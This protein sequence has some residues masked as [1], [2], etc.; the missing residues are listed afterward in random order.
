MKKL[1][2]VFAALGLC[3]LSACHVPT[4]ETSDTGHI[5]PTVSKA[6]YMTHEETQTYDW[7]CD[8]P[9]TQIK[10]YKGSAL[11]GYF[12]TVDG[13][14]YAYNAQEVFTDTDKHY[15]KVETDL[16]VAYLSY[17]YQLDKLTV[18][19]E[20]FKTYSYDQEQDAF[21]PFEDDFGSVVETFSK[22]GR[23]LSWSNTNLGLTNFWFIDKNGNV[24][25]IEQDFENPA[26]YREVLKGSIPAAETVLFT[27]TG[28]IKTASKYYC[29]DS[30]KA[31]FYVSEEATAAY[32]N[33]AF[34]DDLIVLYTD[35]PTHIY[36][37]KL[38]Y[39]IDFF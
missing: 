14:L 39:Q 34:M 2:A 31:C 32:D 25:S 20:E 19:T 6:Q 26:E 18:L 16:N 12:V 24:Y 15:R 9:P 13:D 7:K 23:I 4:E 27:A 1:L 3:M 35:D 22:R 17:H 10:V 29:Y 33:I 28:I 37:H 21:T 30:E 38:V 5:E 8:I 11:E 36:G